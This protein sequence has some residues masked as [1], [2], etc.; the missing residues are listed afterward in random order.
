MLARTDAPIRTDR[1][2]IEES[3]SAVSWGAIVGGAL[4]MA[5]SSILLVALGAGFSLS[6]VSPWPNAGAS[7]K[8]FAIM[9]GVWLIVVQWL[10]SGLGG[11]VAGRLR[12][13]WTA[14]HTDE[15][16]FRDSA[17]GII[18]WALASVLAAAFLTSAISSV[19]GGAAHD[20]STV[21][22]GAAQGASQAG[23]QG[24]TDPYAPSGYLM[25]SLF[26]QERPDPNANTQSAR[27]EATRIVASGLR[28]GDVPPA[29]KTYLAQLVAARTGLSPADAEKR[30]DDVIAKSKQAAQKVREEADTARKAARNTAVFVAF[31]MLIG[32][33]IAGIAGKLGGHHRDV[34]G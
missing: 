17:H 32:A 3:A 28:A 7:A 10:S 16:S 26:R 18:A 27:G 5:A 2:F 11:Y 29:D 21:A 34:L 24:A 9:T 15:V 8:T 22:A 25:D 1:G 12:S 20:A 30:V 19:V 6:T 33:F 23:V 14:L 4:V 31:S 13:R